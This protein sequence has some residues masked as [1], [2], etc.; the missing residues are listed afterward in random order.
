MKFQGAFLRSKVARR[1]FLL[2][3]LSAALPMTVMAIL[4]TVEVNDLLIRQN[5]AE[6]SRLSENYGQAM[7]ERLLSLEDRLQLVAKDASNNSESTVELTP[8]LQGRV[9][10][11]TLM[12]TNEAVSK[13]SGSSSTK[14]WSLTA[15]QK[16]HL[17]T[18]KSLVLSTAGVDGRTYLVYPTAPESADNRALIAEI[19][20]VYLWG[21]SEALPA[22]I[23]ICVL[24]DSVQ[25]LHCSDASKATAMNPRATQDVRN[26]SGQLDWNYAGVKYVA[27]YHDVFMN[28][29]FHGKSWTVIAS[30]AE[31]EVLAPVAKFKRIYLPIIAVAILLVGMLTISQIRRT[32][33]PLERLLDATRS[34]TA[35]R[36]DTRVEISRD[37]EF[38]ELGNSFNSMTAQLG[39]QFN[40]LNTLSEIDRAILSTP[41]VDQ[42]L[43]MVLSRLHNI[44]PADFICITVVDNDSNESVRNYVQDYRAACLPKVTRTRI[45][46]EDLDTL[47]RIGD[48][49]WLTSAEMTHNFL[50]PLAG[51]AIESAYVLP[52]VWKEKLT[53][54]ITLGY[55]VK[56]KATTEFEIH[57]RDFRDRLGVALSSAAREEQLYYQARYDSLTTLPNRAYFKDQL[58]QDIAHSRRDRTSLAVLFI[59]LDHFKN[60]NDTAG[61]AAGDALL[62]EAAQRISRC[63]RQT[64]MVAR[65]GGDEFTVALPSIAS[66]QMASQVCASILQAMSAP[67]LVNGLDTFLSASIGVAV[68]PTDGATGDALLKNADTAMYRA[69]SAGRNRYV[70]FENRMNAEA[71][72]R[73]T[74]ERELRRGSEREEFELHYQAQ[75]DLKTNRICGAEALIRWNH[76]ERG[77][78]SPFHFIPV[79]EEAGLI[80]VIGRQ[81]ITLACNQ[82]RSLVKRG[83]HLERF[84]VNVAARQ[85]RQRDFVDFVA[86]MLRDFAVPALSLELEVTE[87]MFMEPGSDAE[88]MLDKLRDLGVRL[89]LD[90]F[91]TGFS[92]LSYL[93]RLPVDLVKIDR[94]FVKDITFDEES[95]AIVMAIIAMSQTLKKEVIAEGVETAEQL[96]M[97]RELGCDQ[98]QGYYL[99]KPLPFQAFSDFIFR[100]ALANATQLEEI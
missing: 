58:A 19:D 71:V 45:S 75:L 16:A 82:Y 33:V 36:F 85:F 23:D 92:S 64:D 40:A 66:P 48:A 42:V 38:G 41:D 35:R 81:M 31:S 80:D 5:R 34:V 27:G 20:P 24:D 57:A 2:F 6:L 86:S 28:A 55:Q 39:R 72:A 88:N 99:S 93:K 69:K 83:I 96:E 3:V 74:L 97:L 12:D 61:H 10:A 37:D 46:Q 63:V 59:D 21:E 44:V 7:Y 84:S 11:L 17:A 100:H 22:L 95:R 32:L 53:G 51:F 18:G 73:A 89:A 49:T 8:A 98:I 1:I 77:Q 25:L 76:P 68:F 50:L 30:K 43:Q 67:F 52:I 29:R 90:D 26:N 60:V 87:G 79:A 62:Q 94:S 65:L 70:F 13:Q 14:S 9:S 15:P 91:G 54:A 47:L 56:P 78:L 4:S